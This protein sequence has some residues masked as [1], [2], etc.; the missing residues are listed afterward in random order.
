MRPYLTKMENSA[1]E[2]CQSP[3]LCTIQ[4][5]LCEV[6]CVPPSLVPIFPCA[7]TADLPTLGPQNEG[8]LEKSDKAFDEEG[9]APKECRSILSAL[10]FCSQTAHAS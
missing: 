8:S 4:H 1:F 10:S 6:V 3:T 2:G 9:V 5:V 7:L